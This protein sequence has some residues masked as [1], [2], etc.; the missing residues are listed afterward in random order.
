MRARSCSTRL[1]LTPKSLRPSLEA[2]RTCSREPSSRTRHRRRSRATCFGIR[3]QVVAFR[4]NDPGCAARF[5]RPARGRKLTL[6]R[7]DVV[8]PS[9]GSACEET[10]FGVRPA[11]R[12]A[13]PSRRGS[14]CRQSNIG[15]C[16]HRRTLSR[17]GENHAADFR[18]TTR[19]AADRHC[20]RAGGGD[21]RPGERARGRAQRPHRPGGAERSAPA[22]P[23][24]AD[25]GGPAGA[26][27]AR[28]DGSPAA[29]PLGAGQGP[30]RLLS[31]K[32]E[33]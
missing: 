29:G 24:A 11:A 10:Q 30:G 2:E 7:R 32:T 12:A 6:D 3:V 15:G 8:L 26:R 17:S 33:A 25:A 13:R 28:R 20:A 21:Q 1:R 31:G 18:T 16:Y 5:D 23:P 4:A 22:R 27:A 14:G 19:R 9:A